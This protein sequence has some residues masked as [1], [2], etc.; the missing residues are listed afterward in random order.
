MGFC[1]KCKAYR[2]AP[3][4]RMDAMGV[5]DSGS[6][7]CLI[8][9]RSEK[10]AKLCLP[11]IG[12]VPILPSPTR[13]SYLVEATTFLGSSAP[14][15]LQSQN[16]GMFSP[17]SFLHLTSHPVSLTDVCA[18]LPDDRGLSF[19]AAT[20]TPSNQTDTVSLSSH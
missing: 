2:M 14:V 3:S 12:S 19:A 5:H 20:P 9:L 8:S 17:F 6:R 18:D 7:D 4:K 11:T 10:L 13:P 15:C 16:A 1:K